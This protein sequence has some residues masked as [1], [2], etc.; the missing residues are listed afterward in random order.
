MVLTAPTILQPQVR[1]SSKPSMLSTFYIVEIETVIVAGMRKGQ[2]KWKRG[3]D[4]PI[5]KNRFLKEINC[6]KEKVSFSSQ[7]GCKCLILTSSVTKWQDYLLNIWHLKWL[8]SVG[9]KKVIENGLKAT[10]VFSPMMMTLSGFFQLWRH[11]LGL[12]A[13]LPNVGSSSSEIISKNQQK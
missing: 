11:H 3:R 1:I 7:S 2:N 6:F 9:P 12:I 4:C 13:Y 10:S 8:W 5:L